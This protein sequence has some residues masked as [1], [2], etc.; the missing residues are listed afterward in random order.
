MLRCRGG[1]SAE[2]SLHFILLKRGGKSGL[3]GQ[4]AR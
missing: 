1:E 4:G 3:G 2:Q